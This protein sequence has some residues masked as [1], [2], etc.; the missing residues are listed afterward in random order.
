MG[1]LAAGAA[2]L[3]LGRVLQINSGTHHPVASGWLTVAAIS[4]VAVAGA[5]AACDSTPREA[6]LTAGLQP[7]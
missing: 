3:T 4:C 5:P 7:S 2:D 1:V 6:V